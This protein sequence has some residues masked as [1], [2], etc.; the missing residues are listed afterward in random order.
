MTQA[1]RHDPVIDGN[2]DEAYAGRIVPMSQQ[3]S[4]ASL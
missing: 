4:A 3:L 2:G 1:W